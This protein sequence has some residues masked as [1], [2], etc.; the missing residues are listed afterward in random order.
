MMTE[1]KETTEKCGNCGR[2]LAVCVNGHYVCIRCTRY[3]KCKLVTTVR[4]AK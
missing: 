2:K 1:T 3:H 4:T